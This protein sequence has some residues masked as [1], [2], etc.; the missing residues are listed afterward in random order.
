[1]IILSMVVEPITAMPFTIMKS[2]R[3]STTTPWSEKDELSLPARVL[4]WVYPPELC[5]ELARQGS[6]A[7]KGKGPSRRQRVHSQSGAAHLVILA[8]N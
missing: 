3:K 4:W 8:R 6:M 2:T 7:E 1:M 5:G